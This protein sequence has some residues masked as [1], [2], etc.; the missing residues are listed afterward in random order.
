LTTGYPIQVQLQGRLCVV[1][2]GGRVGLRKT[3]GLLRAGARVRLIT[4]DAAPEPAAAEGLEVLRRPYREGDLEG[5]FL[6]FAATDSRSSNAAVAVE[7]RRRQIPV[8][9]ADDPQNSDFSLPAQL[10]RGDLLITVSTD[11]QS[12]ALAA[13]LRN[14]LAEI[15]GPEWETVLA[16]AAAMRRKP[17][18]PEQKT[19]YGG[20][21]LGRLIAA[22]LPALIARNDAE[23]IDQ[24]FTEIL[25]EKVSLADL[26]IQLPKGTP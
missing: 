26:G 5:A 20:K 4:G 13:Q 24:L 22:D 12:P 15:I 9:I 1:I 6:A 11:G 16:V 17:L 2:G 21:I 3:A 7:A 23:K 18:T 25:G 8:N 14:H 19:E 10:A